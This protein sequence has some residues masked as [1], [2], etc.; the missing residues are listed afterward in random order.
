MALVTV[1][2]AK[3]APGATTT[4]MLLAAL[5]PRPTI[6]VDADPNGG[7][8]ALRLPG[9]AG[10][11]LDRERGLLS[12]LPAAR[13]GLG[14]DV[15]RQHLQTAL[16][17]QPVL[18]GLGGPEQSVAVGQQWPVL[19]QA[20]ARMPEADVIVDM[21]QVHARSPHVTMLE[22]AHAAL[23][24]YRPQAT[25]VLHTRRRLEGLTELLAQAA[26]R[27]GVVAVSGT[28][29]EADLAAAAGVLREERDWV[30]DYGSVALDRRAA[31]MFEG[32]EVYRPERT[33][34]A[35]SGRALAERLAE[36][37][38]T[39]DPLGGG[40]HDGVQDDGLADR[41]GHG[42]DDRDDGSR[43]LPG[44]DDAGGR[45]GRRTKGRGLALGGRRRRA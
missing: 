40:V 43:R 45:G 22:H 17:G 36:D 5:W 12:L 6:L 31:V 4:A 9:E 2:S 24:V 25:T 21:G 13:R 39:L 41:S 27:T 23:W 1:M 11:T 15:V 14:G 35:R 7:D 32:G 34:L 3:G 10:R 8:I 29:Q 28:D 18:A 30:T 26:A 42:G 20:F 16:G 37:V 38:R 19:A 44:D 33:L